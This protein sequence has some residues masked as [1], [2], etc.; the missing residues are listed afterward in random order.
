MS[1]ESILRIKE[2]EAEAEALLAKARADAQAMLADA[3]REGRALLQNA[4]AEAG[5]ASNAMLADVR[6]R[7]LQ[8]EERLEGESLEECAEMRKN[9]LLRRKA[10]QKVIMRGVEAK[11]RFVQ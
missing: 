11:C 5:A 4:E 8:L 9:V 2:A 10:A 1:R 7:T 3:E 6:E